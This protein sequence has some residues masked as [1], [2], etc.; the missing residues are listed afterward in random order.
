MQEIKDRKRWI[1]VYKYD[2]F[3]YRNKVMKQMAISDFECKRLPSLKKF[4]ENEVSGT[5]KPYVVYD[6]KEKIIV[7][8]FTLVSS[9]MIEADEQEDVRLVDREKDVLKILPSIEIEHFAVNDKYIDFMQR[10]GYNNRG[11]GKYIFEQF[12]CKI[13]VSL[14]TM[15]NFSYIILHA[16]N[17]P[18]VIEA[19]YGM[20]FETFED[21]ENN[22]IPMMQNIVSLRNSYS[23]SCKF[24]YQEL[25]SVL[26]KVW[27]EE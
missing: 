26:V 9:C 21:D 6:I 2:R 18:K 23:G 14:S 1:R 25:E 3:L 22:V 11:I 24:M 12:I 19:Y 16:Y 13:I 5:C 27:K 17:H 10:R 8:Y 7:G 15:V 20:G 4:I